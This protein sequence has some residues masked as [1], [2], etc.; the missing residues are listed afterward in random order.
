M[1]LPGGEGAIGELETDRGELEIGGGELDNIGGEGGGTPLNGG[2]GL[3]IGGGPRG[4]GYP[5]S[6]GG[7][8]AGAGPRDA[9]GLGGGLVIGGGPRGPG[10]PGG[11][12]GVPRYGEL[13][14]GAELARGEAP[15]GR[16]NGIPGEPGGPRAA[17]ISATKARASEGFRETWLVIG[18]VISAAGGSR[19][20]DPGLDVGVVG[21][22]FGVVLALLGDGRGR[23]WLGDSGPPGG[24]EG[25][26]SGAEFAKGDR[27]SGGPRGLN[28]GGE[29]TGAGAVA[30]G[31]TGSGGAFRSFIFI[32]SGSSD[33]ALGDFGDK[34]ASVFGPLRKF[35]RN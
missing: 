31:E 9:K 12:D 8:V 22:D 1:N 28:G 30:G 15:I 26:C 24:D 16:G 6:G 5:G 32:N 29:N 27:G 4:P 11:G 13:G 19:E 35:P 7:G 23:P 14:I 17:N 25:P 33:S 10:I 34:S 20:P 2:G 18:G 3:V 21:L